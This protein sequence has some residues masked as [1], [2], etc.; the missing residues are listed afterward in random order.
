MSSADSERTGL[1]NDRPTGTR[2]PDLARIFHNL[3]KTPA[4]QTTQTAKQGGQGRNS[5]LDIGVQIVYFV[6]LVLNNFLV[7][8]GQSRQTRSNLRSH[9]HEVSV[10]RPQASQHTMTP[11]RSRSRL[12]FIEAAG[13]LCRRLGLPRSLGQIYGLLFFSATPLSLDDIVR[14]LDISKASASTGTRQLAAWGAVRQVWVPGD[15]RDFFEVVP[16]VGAVLRNIYQDF[17]KPRIAISQRRFNELADNVQ[18]DLA[19]G[20]LS[21][22]E[23]QVYNQRLKALSRFQRKLETAAPLFERFL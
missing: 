3:V 12:Q 2:N 16:D 1:C 8:A 23:T 20:I 15:R 9:R 14:Y 19:Q 10:S 21:P 4:S 18:K 7:H 6:Q 13:G 11:I 17:F 22:E 5:A